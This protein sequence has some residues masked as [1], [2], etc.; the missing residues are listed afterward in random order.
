[1]PGRAVVVLVALQSSLRAKP[2]PQVVGGDGRGT[3]PPLAEA[4]RRLIRPRARCR[5]AA[6]DDH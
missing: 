6:S 2:Q 1:M 4:E 5:R 3:E